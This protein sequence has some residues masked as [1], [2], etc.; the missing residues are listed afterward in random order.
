[1]HVSFTFW[2][3]KTVDFFCE[4]YSRVYHHVRN[5]KARSC[6]SP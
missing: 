4:E 2:T 3:Q 5:T 1:M 6:Q